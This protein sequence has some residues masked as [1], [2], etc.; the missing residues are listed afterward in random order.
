MSRVRSSVGA[1]GGA[2]ADGGGFASVSLLSSQRRGS[3]TGDSGSNSMS[4]ASSKM[5]TIRD[6]WTTATATVDGSV[7]EKMRSSMPYLDSLESRVVE[8]FLILAYEHSESEIREGKP[9]TAFRR[10]L[11]PMVQMAVRDIAGELT[12]PLVV[13]WPAVADEEGAATL[14]PGQGDGGFTTAFNLN[15]IDYRCRD[16]TRWEKAARV[17]LARLAKKGHTERAE[18]LTL[19]EIRE[20]LREHVFFNTE[21]PDWTDVCIIFRGLWAATVEKY[22]LRPMLRLEDPQHKVACKLLTELLHPAMMRDRFKDEIK[23]GVINTTADFWLRLCDYKMYHRALVDSR[24]AAPVSRPSSGPRP[25][26][27]QQRL[28]TPA[29]TATV[30][31]TSS[32]ADVSA[33][34]SGDRSCHNC[35]KPGHFARDCRS[36]ST[37]PGSWRT[38]N[39]LTTSTAFSSLSRGGAAPASGQRVLI[40]GRV[41]TGSG[42]RSSAGSSPARVKRVE[43]VE[44][45]GDDAADDGGVL[46]YVNGSDEREPVVEAVSTPGVDSDAEYEAMHRDG[47]AVYRVGVRAVDTRNLDGGS[48]VAQF[49]GVNVPMTMDS[50]ATRSV[51]STQLADTLGLVSTPIDN[52]VKVTMSSEGAVSYAESVVHIPELRVELHSGH[53]KVLSDVELLVVPGLIDSEVLIGVDTQQHNGMDYIQWLQRNHFNPP[54]DDSVRSP[55]RSVHS[56]TRVSASVSAVVVESVSEPVGESVSGSVSESVGEPVMEPV[57]PVDS[58]PVPAVARQGTFPVTDYT[59]NRSRS[60]AAPVVEEGEEAVMPEF[61]DQDDVEQVWKFLLESWKQA[62][63][64]GLS[65]RAVTRLMNM[66]ASKYL[67]S[68]RVGF[69]MGDGMAIAP[70]YLEVDGEQLKDVKLGRRAYTKEDSDFMQL[71]MDRLQ[72]YGLVEWVPV[73]RFASPAY[74]VD[75][76]NANPLDPLER[77]KRLVI[78]Y[79]RLNRATWRAHVEMPDVR[80]F[81][82][83]VAGKKWFGVIDLSEGYWQIPLHPLCQHWFAFATD[84]GVYV[85]TRLVQGAVNSPAVF[86]SVMN[87]VLGDLVGKCCIV[88]VDDI[89]VFAD[90]EEELEAVWESVLSRLTS[91]NVKIAAK[92]TVWAS[93][94]IKFLGMIFSAAGVRHDPEYVKALLDMPAPDNGEDLRSWMMMCNWMRKHIHD[95]AILMEPLQSIWSAVTAVTGTQKGT[96]SRRV[97]LADVGWNDGGLDAWRAVNQAIAHAATLAHPDPNKTIVMFSDASDLFYGCVIAQGDPEQMSRLPVEEWDLEPL[98]FMSGKFSGATLNYPT[99]EKEGY[100]ILQGITRHGHLFRR[101]QP[102]LVLCDHRNLGF[103]FDSAGALR[104]GRRVAAARLDRWWL[105]LREYH[106]DIQYIPGM[107]NVVSDLFTRG[108]AS[109]S[110][111]VKRVDVL[112]QSRVSRVAVEEISVDDVPSRAEIV[113]VQRECGVSKGDVMLCNVSLVDGVWQ[114]STGQLFVPSAYNLR[115]RIYVAAHQGPSAHRGADTTAAWIREH[116][117]WPS[118]SSFVSDAVR[119]CPCCMLTRG[120]KAARV[121]FGSVRT[122]TR[123]NQCVH[124]DYYLVRNTSDA[125]EMHYI[126]TLKDE[127]SRFVRL[128]PTPAATA[129]HVC[130][131]LQQWYADF[132]PF[133]ELQTDQ[134]SHFANDLL[135]RFATVTG[136]QHHFTIRY[137]PWSNGVIERLNRDVRESLSAIMTE[138]R[139]P[140]GDWPVVLPVVASVINNTPSVSLAGYTPRTVFTGRPAVSPLR[141]VTYTASTGVRRVEKLRIEPESLA[142]RVDSFVRQMEAVDESVRVLL[143]KQVQSRAKVPVPVFDVGDFVMA[144]QIGKQLKDATRPIW[145]GPLMVVRRVNDRRYVVRDV[146][147]SGRVEEC[148]AAQLKRFAERDIV[149]T[150]GLRDLAAHSSSGFVVDHISRHRWRDDVCEL[151]VVWAVSDDDD[152]P[153]TWQLAEDMMLQTPVLVRRYVKTVTD[154][155]E[156]RKLARMFS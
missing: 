94:E 47:A 111:R 90:S 106:Y 91:A 14:L 37:A 10:M 44:V 31:P 58:V 150:D 6:N 68:F 102:A 41:S 141:I 156:R 132:G 7:R 138:S 127:F 45:D 140:V 108:G 89:L 23:R 32:S 18:R 71:T 28:L 139:L 82:E 52:P 36:S 124:L 49:G 30:V 72:R 129:E 65:Q 59:S 64:A 26:T 134:G 103:L 143:H 3:H 146:G 50:G 88:F 67:H 151:R 93:Q 110:V 9:R 55:S 96:A 53:H 39:T 131:A 51:I 40:P 80:L 69:Q 155:D 63:V 100:A 130:V 66:V 56:P 29:A 81:G 20:L 154:G 54:S 119:A 8:S 27:G 97:A 24:A 42:A 117:V 105:Q 34:T 107:Q 33:G 76:H 35:G 99:V 123:V 145:R 121:P 75:K 79:R 115:W 43:I 70:V 133:E 85:P 135:E 74:P 118:L 92:K 83:V 22:G 60:D 61:L 5:R 109:D 12:G 4:F 25:S 104:D 142:S 113:R 1:S 152:A 149:V 57:V 128:V 77:R 15:N 153:E 86:Q 98:A 38:G 48:G 2:G 46:V 73:A 120:G 137:A 126:L 114:S 17:T 13:D 147:P 16:Y 148:H 136:I 11:S 19:A 21:Y 122:A 87:H 95:F 116:Y 112:G 144:A 84:K 101:A 78:D 125:S 62:R